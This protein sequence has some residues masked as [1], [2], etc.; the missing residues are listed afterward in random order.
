M[1]KEKQMQE[2]IDLTKK[3]IQKRKEIVQSIK[4][5]GSKAWL[6]EC[7]PYEFIVKTLNR[8]D[9]AEAVFEDIDDTKSFDELL[10]ERSMR[11]LEK[12]CMYPDDWKEIVQSGGG[13][14]QSVSEEV[15]NLSG[16]STRVQEL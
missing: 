2:A 6:I 14:L 8:S 9:Y 10:D 16:F 12:T 1:D 4:E 13:Y 3:E 11:I 7:G 15:L 5:G